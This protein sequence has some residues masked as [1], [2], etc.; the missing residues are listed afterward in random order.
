MRRKRPWLMRLGV[1]AA[2]VMIALSVLVYTQLFGGGVKF[3]ADFYAAGQ[4]DKRKG[5]SYDAYAA[6]LK[7]Y[8][9]NR[10]MV[11]YTALKESRQ[12]LDAFVRAVAYLDAEVYKAWDA[13]AKVAFW[14]N[15]YNALTLKAILD[16]YPI[17][18]SLLRRVAYPRNSIRQIP[19]VWDKLQFLVMGEKM[20]LNGI[21]HE[22]LRKEFGEPRIHMALVCA[23]MGC[24]PLR[25]EPYLG[26]RLSA[27]LD[28]Q[29][30]KFLTDPAKFRIDRVAGE[31][32]ASA[33]FKWFGEDF[34]ANH[35]PE[36]GF[37]GHKDAVRATLSFA[38]GH[39]SKE[40]AAYLAEQQYEVEYLKY[41]WSLNEQARKA[42]PA[43]D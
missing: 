5:F 40:D 30:R 36:T 33:I 9:D 32:H 7:A 2:V 42:K 18:P 22:V 12:Q 3:D 25:D 17:R 10:G 34:V 38:A 41:D 15:A 31:V 43:Q 16:H 35:K 1:A 29:A 37:A 28:E 6:A 8:V 11:N 13:S 39:L 21:E 27:Q 23:A 26:E 20:T 4:A 19:G 24:P 14:I